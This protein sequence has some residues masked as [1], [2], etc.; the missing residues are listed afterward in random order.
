MLIS[1]VIY[2][3]VWCC[4][5]WFPDLSRRWLAF[6]FFLRK[7][8]PLR[9]TLSSSSAASDVYKRQ[10]VYEGMTLLWVYV[11]PT[12]TVEKCANRIYDRNEDG[13]MDITDSCLLYTSPSPRDGL[14]AR[15]PASAWKKKQCGFSWYLELSY[16]A[17]TL[18]TS[19]TAGDLSCWATRDFT[20]QLLH[21]AS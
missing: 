21:E 17:G 7:R 18:C 4:L 14:L 20:T 10:I 12:S 8:R 15:M 1:V 3:S 2:I 11:P 13:D 6:F 5:V 9:S 19:R 16:I